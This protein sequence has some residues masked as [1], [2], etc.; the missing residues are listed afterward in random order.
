MDRPGTGSRGRPRTGSRGV[1]EDLSPWLA[2]AERCAGPPRSW[3]PGAAAELAA[4]VAR[5]TCHHDSRSR[6]GARAAPGLAAA[7]GRDVPEDL[8]GEL[9][10]GRA[11]DAEPRRDDLAS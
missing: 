11:S 7:G 3:Q 1:P 10:E 2:F 6:S 8:S 9:W 4:A 5:G